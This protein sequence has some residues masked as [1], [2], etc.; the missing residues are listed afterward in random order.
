[1]TPEKRETPN[2]LLCTDS[3]SMSKGRPETFQGQVWGRSS[4]CHAEFFYY[5]SSYFCALAQYVASQRSEQPNNVKLEPIKINK[6]M[7]FFY[8][9]QVKNPFHLYRT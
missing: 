8:L 1:M 6:R 4:R 2:S 7:F 5:I 3:Q 9:D